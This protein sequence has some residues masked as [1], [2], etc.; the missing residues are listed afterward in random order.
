[1]FLPALG[2]AKS[3]TKDT[4]LRTKRVAF[5]SRG[6]SETGEE[7]G[8]ERNLTGKESERKK[9][10]RNEAIV[11]VVVVVARSNCRG[12]GTDVTRLVAGIDS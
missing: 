7:D 11:V 4:I 6:Q 1:M 5:V 3:A 2:F 9:G 12:R 8:E 10:W